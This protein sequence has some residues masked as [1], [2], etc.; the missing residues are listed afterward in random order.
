M[1]MMLT[2]FLGKTKAKEFMGDLWLLLLEAQESEYGIPRELI[3]LK[4][5]ELARKKVNIFFL[6]SYFLNKMFKTTLVYTF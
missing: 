1:Q 5:A 3:E 6:L 4:K 2:G